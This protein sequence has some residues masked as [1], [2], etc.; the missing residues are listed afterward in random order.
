M[1][2]RDIRLYGDP[3]LRQPCEPIERIDDTVRQLVAD[4]LDT[5]RPEGRAG[6]AAPQIGVGL[7]AFS[8]D[9]DGRTGYLLNPRITKV[10][11]EVA[12]IEE[13]CLSVPGLWFPTPRH[14]WARAEG[15]DLGGRPVAVEG[16]G[17]LGQALQH[18]TDHLQGIVYLHRL[19]KERRREAMREMRGTSWF[20]TPRG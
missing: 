2:V 15:I 16:D 12:D 11:D 13:G 17:V 5:V 19:P 9:V 20:L 1:T 18:E 7:Q 6:V 3:V 8:Y 4:L 10:S 14:T